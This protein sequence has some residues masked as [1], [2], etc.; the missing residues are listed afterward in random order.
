VGGNPGLFTYKFPKTAL[1]RQD[2]GQHRPLPP[3]DVWSVPDLWAERHVPTGLL[4]L[5]LPMEPKNWSRSHSACLPL[6]RDHQGSGHPRRVRELHAQVPHS[7]RGW[8]EAF[9]PS[10]MPTTARERLRPVAPKSQ[11][12]PP[13]VYNQSSRSSLHPPPK[14]Q[15][16]QGSQEPLLASPD[17][18]VQTAP[19]KRMFF[20]LL[21][22]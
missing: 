5:L 11:L 6:G 17:L 12:T 14:Y 9:Q 10:P 1:A 16:H 22:T 19:L 2:T 21:P 20:L 4:P 7:R 3:P 8:D 13:H 15:E 18:P